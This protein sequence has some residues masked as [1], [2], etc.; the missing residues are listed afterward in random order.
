MNLNV[1][2]T[3]VNNELDV[4]DFVN[5]GF[6][7]DFIGFFFNFFNYGLLAD[8]GTRPRTTYLAKLRNPSPLL[9]GAVD[10]HATT[11]H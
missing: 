2:V 7:T 10:S 11:E 4:T 3:K 5:C 6:V 9:G 8:L 1:F